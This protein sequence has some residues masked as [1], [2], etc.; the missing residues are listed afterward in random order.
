LTSGIVDLGVESADIHTKLAEMAEGVFDKVLYVGVDGEREFKKI[1][2]DRMISNR[3]ELIK[4]LKKMGDKDV[5][6]IE[7][8]IKNDILL[9]LE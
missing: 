3:G 4:Y 1:F 2:K 9:Y 8:K 7:G 5:I 6:L